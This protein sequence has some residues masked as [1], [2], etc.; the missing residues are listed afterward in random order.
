MAQ[1][2]PKIPSEVKRQ[3]RQES[4][5]GCCVCGHPFI[6]YHHIVP[7]KIEHH[8]RATD[9]MAICNNCHYLCTTGALSVDY[10]RSAKENPKNIVSSTI[11]GILF[12][13]SKKLVVNLGGAQAIETPELIVLGGNNILSARMDD[14]SGRILISAKIYN[15]SGIL[16]AKLENNDWFANP[17]TIWDFETSPHKA[18]IRQKKSKIIFDIDTRGDEISIRGRWFYMG[19]MIE[20]TPM[21]VRCGGIALTAITIAYCNS[22]INV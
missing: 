13:N 16:I 1:G 3:L 11:N 4:G 15:D 10:Q 6:Q 19:Q 12:V 20:F 7:W 5:F 17:S 2:R 18:T 8:F 9:M 14:G 21:E 22:F